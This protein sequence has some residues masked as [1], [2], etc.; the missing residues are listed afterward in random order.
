MRL[1][2]AIFRFSGALLPSPAAEATPPTPRFI[3]AL[4]AGR[5]QHVVIYGT[6]LG[7]GGAWVPQLRQTLDARF[8]GLVKLTNSARRRLH[9]VRDQRRRHALRA[10]SRYHPPPRRHHPRPHR[11][12]PSCLRSDSPNHE[13]RFRQG[14]RRL[15]AP[16][17]QA[18]YQQIYRDAAG[19]RGLLLIDHS[20]AWNR[21]LATA[22]E[23]A[24]KKLIPD[25]VHPNADGWRRI[26]TPPLH[27]AL[28][29]APSP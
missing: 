18:A 2:L 20:I 17:N 10:L 4:R 8:P 16:R 12:R 29:I 23:A 7:K 15:R 6:S 24:V 14:R 27:R 28:D 13:P 11:H 19:R 21:L 26:V 22:G 25:G 3:T 5:A 9:R 1:L